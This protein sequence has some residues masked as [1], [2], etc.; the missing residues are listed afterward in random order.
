[1]LGLIP[2]AFKAGILTVAIFTILLVAI[3]SLLIGKL[4]LVLNL[5]YILVKLVAWKTGGG[6]EPHEHFSKS[7][8]APPAA[9]SAN[10][11]HLHIHNAAPALYPV[12]TSS[13]HHE[14]PYGAH[15]QQLQQRGPSIHIEPAP[16]VSNYGSYGPPPAYADSWSSNSG[17]YQRREQ[18]GNDYAYVDQSGIGVGA[19]AAAVSHL[20]SQRQVH[21]PVD[22][23]TTNSYNLL[24]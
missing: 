6:H 23:A 2:I 4:L 13:L 9:P 8:P 21:Q 11:I 15:V 12:A 18:T 3:K 5:G 24:S 14:L 10:D 19:A 22:I 20:H 7:W 17:G 16:A 1:M